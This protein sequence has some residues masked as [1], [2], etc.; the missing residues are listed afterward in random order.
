M[1]T[2]VEGHRLEVAPDSSD[3]FLRVGFSPVEAKMAKLRAMHESAPGNVRF[4]SVILNE[5]PISCDDRE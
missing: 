5:H 1:P 3:T 4:L 2:G